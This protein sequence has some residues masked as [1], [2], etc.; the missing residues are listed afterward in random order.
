MKQPTNSLSNTQREQQLRFQNSETNFSDKEPIH[1]PII[2]SKIT[3]EP[4]H[5][6]TQNMFDYQK[7]STRSISKVN[8]KLQE[9]I[10]RTETNS[11]IL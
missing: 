5:E 9:E 8:S 7:L 10:T 11:K 2:R 6:P 4:Q 1:F 3:L